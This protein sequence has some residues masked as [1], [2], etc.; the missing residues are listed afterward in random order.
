MA[1]TTLAMVATVLVG[2]LY[3]RKDRPVPKWLKKL[4]MD[5]VA[6]VLCM[7]R[8]GNISG[9]NAAFMKFVHLL[10]FNRDLCSFYLKLLF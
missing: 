9:E 2:N 6:R 10:Q 1:I 7:G 8:D 4:M 5:H 3:E